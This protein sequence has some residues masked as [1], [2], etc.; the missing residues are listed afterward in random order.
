M[1]IAIGCGPTNLT[2]PT[3]DSAA[4]LI[5]EPCLFHPEEPI[6]V[7]ESTYHAATGCLPSMTICVEVD[8]KMPAGTAAT[9]METTTAP[10]FMLFN[11]TE[12]ESM[13]NEAPGGIITSWGPEL[14]EVSATTKTVT[15]VPES[16]MYVGVT[17]VETDGGEESPTG[18]KVAEDG[19][20]ATGKATT[21][22]D[23]TTIPTASSAANG[24][25][26]S[27]AVGSTDGSGADRAAL[28]VC[29][30]LVAALSA[31]MVYL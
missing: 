10:R 21:S 28:S 13:M 19:A 6:T 25:D 20:E 9:C 16:M 7:G 24:T 3:A 2:S 29:A 5:P 23:A 4:I 17:L 12:S 18:T 22:M 26:D 14:T 11:E 30:G 1:T 8:C 27:S 15:V 31:V